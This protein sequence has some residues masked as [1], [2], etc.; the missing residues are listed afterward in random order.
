MEHDF[1]IGLLYKIMEPVGNIR[2]TNELIW[3]WHNCFFDFV[4]DA[5]NMNALELEL[6]NE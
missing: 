4:W 5:I 3:I 1:C 6:I 2:Q